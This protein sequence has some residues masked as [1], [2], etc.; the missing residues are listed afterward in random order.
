MCLTVIYSWSWLDHKIIILIQWLC[1]QIYLY[2]QNELFS[3]QSSI[4]FCL[5]MTLFCISN[6]WLA[7]CKMIFSFRTSFFCYNELF[8]SIES[9][10]QLIWILCYL[11]FQLQFNRFLSLIIHLSFQMHMKH[12]YMSITQI[13]NWWIVYIW[14]LLESDLEQNDWFIWLSVI[15]ESERLCCFKILINWHITIFSANS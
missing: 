6:C 2:F 1:Q 8:I 10:I 3:H 9:L 14:V 13:W 11:C 7:W 5:S 12:D 4:E 15:T